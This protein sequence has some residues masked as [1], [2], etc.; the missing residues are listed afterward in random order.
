V[1][2]RAS[3]FDGQHTKTAEGVEMTPP[4]KDWNPKL[5]EKP[6]ALSE[7]LQQILRAQHSAA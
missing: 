7:I 5:Q 1:A 2:R 3:G 6:T 4:D